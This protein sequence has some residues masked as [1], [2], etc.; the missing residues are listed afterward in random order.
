MQFHSPYH[1]ACRMMDKKT[2]DRRSLLQGSATERDLGNVASR[3]V[4]VRAESRYL[5]NPGWET[6]LEAALPALLSRPGLL[7]GNPS[8]ARL[9]VA[10]ILGVQRRV[11]GRNGVAWRAL[12]DGEMV[13]LIGDQRNRLDPG[14]TGKDD[15][16]ALAGEVD[17]VMGPASGCA[18]CR[19][20][21]IRHR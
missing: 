12:K 16:D 21:R 9:D 7:S 6:S 11:V 17:A 2:E 4:E 13:C 18:P 15:A 8:I 20:R 10:L 19:A 1:E 3:Q 5:A 14:R